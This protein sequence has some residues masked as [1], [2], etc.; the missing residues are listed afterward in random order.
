MA[1]FID[2]FDCI[3]DPAVRQMFADTI[4]AL[5][6]HGV[7]ATI[8]LIGVADDVTQLISRHESIE[9]ALVQVHMPRMSP[10]ELEEIVR[11]GMDYIEIRVDAGAVE[12]IVS[13]S[14]GLPHYIHLLAREAAREAINEESKVVRVKDVLE[15]LGSAIS[16]RNHQ[17]LAE[18]Y[19]L[20]T[21][22]SRARTLY[23]DVLLAA[24]LAPADQLGYFAPGDLREPLGRI[25]E[26][27][28][29]TRSYSQHLHDLCGRSRGETLQKAGQPRRFRFRFRNP[30]M[31]PYLIMRALADE[32]LDFELLDDFLAP[33]G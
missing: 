20:A 33:S 28:H 3:V 7:N 25:V 31:R 11:N 4:K 8:V 22:S 6:D 2:E 26:R 32:R 9:R 19:H 5:A 10:A 17:T 16:R 23:P 27:P 21:A 24:A 15:G 13:L 30:S 18:D 1:I 14:Q 12:R 29:D